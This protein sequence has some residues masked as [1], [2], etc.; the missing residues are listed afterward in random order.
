MP[1][2]RRGLQ[3][4]IQL[5]DS[6]NQQPNVLTPVKVKMNI[7]DVVKNMKHSTTTNTEDIK[8]LMDGYYF[9]LAA[10]QI[11][12]NTPDTTDRYCDIWF[13]QNGVDVPNSSVRMQLSQSV[14]TGVIIT[15]TILY[16]KKGDI[17]NVMMA[18]EDLS[19]E[20]LL[21]PF[22]P[23]YG[24]LVPSIIFSMYLI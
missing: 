21:K 19:A 2:R 12:I 1:D 24:P 13:A 23:E 6:T 18:V 9:I 11:G 4:Y 7:N 5:S 15:Q 3:A 22:I 20:I 10:P 8:V 16:C 17:I 14:T